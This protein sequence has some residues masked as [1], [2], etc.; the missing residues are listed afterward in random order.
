MVQHPDQITAEVASPTKPAFAAIGGLQRTTGSALA[1]MHGLA[2]D[3]G[4]AVG[5]PAPSS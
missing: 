5:P 3:D 4:S 1:E 2:R